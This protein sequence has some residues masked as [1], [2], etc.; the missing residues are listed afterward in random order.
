MLEP[1]ADDVSAVKEAL[2]AE[3][4]AKDFDPAVRASASGPVPLLVLP[5]VPV[6]DRFFLPLALHFSR[7]SGGTYT[8][9]MNWGEYIHYTSG[10]AG[11][12]RRSQAT[13]AFR[14]APQ[15]DWRA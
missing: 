11:A 12:D 1:M 10:A 8:R 5:A 3:H 4:A 15:V 7:D 13:R 6:M 14:L 9:R 2:R